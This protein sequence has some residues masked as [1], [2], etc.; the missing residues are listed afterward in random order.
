MNKITTDLLLDIG[1][2]ICYAQ[3]LWDSIGGTYDLTKVKQ[4]QP[5]TQLPYLV[6]EILKQSNF[7]DKY[8]W[9]GEMEFKCD[10]GNVKILEY[11]I[12]TSDWC[13]INCNGEDRKI[14][15]KWLRELYNNAK[16]DVGGNNNP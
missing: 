1:A 7:R 8:E 5:K 11:G 14:S 15:K 4:Y 13:I 2:N 12:N 16:L 3:K 10:L 9:D 6:N